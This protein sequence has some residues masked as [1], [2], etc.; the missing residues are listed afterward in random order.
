M[1]LDLKRFSIYWLSTTTGSLRQNDDSLHFALS[2]TW[3]LMNR[4]AAFWRES[5]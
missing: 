4:F 1:L 3:R 5:T 2:I